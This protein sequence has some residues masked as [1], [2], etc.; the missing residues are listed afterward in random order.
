MAGE[1]SPVFKNPWLRFIG[2]LILIFVILWILSIISGVLIPFMMALIMAYIL[3]PV[4][5]W[6]ETQRIGRWKVTRGAAIGLLVALFA[7]LICLFLFVAVPNAVLAAKG[8]LAAEQFDNVKEFL[9]RKWQ[10]GVET[11]L[12]STSEDRWA[13]ASRLVSD[14][15]E[16]RTAADAVGQSLRTIVLSTFTAIMWV[17][18]FFLFFV[19][20]VYLLLDIDRVRERVSEL[21][22]LRFRDEILRIAHQID[23]NLK[24]FFRGQVVVVCVLMCIFTI[25][26]WIVG[27]PF[28]YIVGVTGGLAAFVP[29]F[30]LAAGMVPAVI[31]SFAQ[32]QDVWHP[33]AAAA[34]FGAGIF[35]DNVFV[36]PKVIGTRVGMHPVTIIL[37][38]LVFGTLFGFFG[39]LFAIPI[40]AVVKVFAHELF[41]R[42]RASALYTGGN[43]EDELGHEGIDH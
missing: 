3:D 7:A 11:W 4:V 14:L 8:W 35:V 1:L 33:L 26:L 23:V 19:V 43:E 10:L 42:Y 25:G 16:N 28:W 39:V 31:L 13:I 32:Y 27:C 18:Q 24:A 9:P 20:T 38:I 40:A 41:T 17:F 29:Y 30:A 5:D 6:L 34:V 36:T 12:G 37:S 2:L 15:L 21:L 22:P